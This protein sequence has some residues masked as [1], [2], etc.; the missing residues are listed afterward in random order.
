MSNDNNKEKI[1][2]DEY[3]TEYI[4]DE[5]GN[6]RPPMK[7]SKEYTSSG[8]TTYNSSSGHCPL[9]GRLNCCGNCFK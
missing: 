3:G 8:F 7:T 1:Y 6:K 5:K 9:C 4:L 2:F